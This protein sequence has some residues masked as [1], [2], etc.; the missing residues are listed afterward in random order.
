MQAQPLDGNAPGLCVQ[1]PDT[2]EVAARVFLNT[3]TDGAGRPLGRIDGYQSGHQLQ[4]VI[5]LTVPLQEGDEAGLTQGRALAVLEHVFHLLNV[6]HD[7]AFVSPP[8]PVALQYRAAGNRSLSVG[9]VVMLAD[10]AFSVDSVGF[11]Q[12]P[13]PTEA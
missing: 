1:L 11:S 10:C 6:G 4:E 8:D 7:P 3:A 12:I 5:S 13:V 2:R 9:D